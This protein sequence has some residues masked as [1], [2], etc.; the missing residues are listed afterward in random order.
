MHVGAPSVR[1]ALAHARK[2]LGT[3][4]TVTYDLIHDNE[5][6]AIDEMTSGC[7]TLTGALKDELPKC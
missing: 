6:W 3:P 4:T 1:T 2:N 5:G 7:T